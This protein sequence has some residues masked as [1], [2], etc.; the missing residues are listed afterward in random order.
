[1]ID[2]KSEVLGQSEEVCEEE[3]YVHEY[4]KCKD[5]YAQMNSRGHPIGQWKTWYW[6]QTNIYK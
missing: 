2:T 4:N 1:M 6:I 3:M 5:K